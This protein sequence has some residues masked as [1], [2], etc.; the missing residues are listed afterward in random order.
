MDRQFRTRYLG[1]NKQAGD[2]SA[3]ISLSCRLLPPL[4]LR[5]FLFLL[6]GLLLLLD[7]SAQIP[8]VR[9]LRMTS[10]HTSFPDTG[11]VKGYLY[12]SVFYT[13]RDHYQDSSVLLLFPSGIQDD[14]RVDLVFWFHGWNNNSD[15]AL[16]FYELKK[17]FAQSLRRAVFVLAQTAVNAPDSYG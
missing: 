15:T 7:C 9:M 12:D 17:Q 3:L 2:L 13:A 6:G 16:Q 4:L 1:T 11:R 5:P 14:E 8:G 10:S